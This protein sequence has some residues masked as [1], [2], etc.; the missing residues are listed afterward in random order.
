MEICFPEKITA[1]GFI[2]LGKRQCRVVSTPSMNT[3]SKFKE[4]G[5]KYDHSTVLFSC[6]DPGGAPERRF[7]R[8]QI[9]AW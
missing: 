9:D 5:T 4:D 8:L 7:W 1:C 3:Y 2:I 6:K